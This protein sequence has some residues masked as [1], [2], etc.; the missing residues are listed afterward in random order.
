[1]ITFRGGEVEDVSV[2]HEHVDLFN[3]LNRLSSKLLQGSLKLLV[4]GSAVFVNLLNLSSNR[5]LSAST[6]C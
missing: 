5:S 6:L 4:I 1:M 2:V 3:C